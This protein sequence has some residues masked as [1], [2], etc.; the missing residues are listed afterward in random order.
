MGQPVS[1]LVLMVMEPVQQ[2]N[3]TPLKK[4]PIINGCGDDDS[5]MASGQ[6]PRLQTCFTS[7]W[8]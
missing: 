3:G 4:L 2:S 1:L 6:T 8:C 7:V 5:S